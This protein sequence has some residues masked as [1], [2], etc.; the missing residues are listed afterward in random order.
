MDLLSLCQMLQSWS[1]W[2]RH[3]VSHSPVIAKL[4]LWLALALKKVNGLIRSLFFFFFFTLFISIKRW[5]TTRLFYSGKCWLYTCM[6]IAVISVALSSDCNKMLCV[7]HILFKKGE[8]NPASS[9]DSAS[10]I[11]FL[12][13][14]S[15]GR[16]PD[17][18]ALAFLWI[19]GSL[20]QSDFGFSP[21]IGKYMSM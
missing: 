21:Q 5:Q 4:H 19:W 9:P 2:N 20:C 12:S 3:S 10:Q 11:P 17:H 6:N 7:R 16:K 8:D 1:Y 13:S 15:P 18:C 14:L